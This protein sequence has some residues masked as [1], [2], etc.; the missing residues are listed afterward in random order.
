M[1]PESINGVV[2]PLTDRVLMADS[3]LDN[4]G[5]FDSG[6]QFDTSKRTYN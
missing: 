4:S 1:Q 3:T 6:N 5:E 2:T